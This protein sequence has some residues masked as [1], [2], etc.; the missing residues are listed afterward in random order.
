VGGGDSGAVVAFDLASGKEKWKWSGDAPAYASPVVITVGD[1][2]LVIAETETKL[3]ALGLTDGKLMWEIPF[4]VPGRGYNAATPI[5]D[6]DKLIY[7]G[8][9]RGATAV[10][11]EKKGDAVTAQ[12]L[13]K[14]PDNSVMFDTPVLKNGLLFGLSAANDFFCV[15]AKDGKTVW[16]ASSAPATAGD[17][18]GGGGGRGGRGRGGYGSIVDAGSVLLALTPSSELIAFE[19]NAKA[20]NEIARIKIAET[21]THAYP[22]ASGNRLF[23]KDQDAVTLWTVP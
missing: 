15:D 14:N 5:V 23:I 7:A 18:P 19:P 10:K 13:W 4:P 20:Y 16:T 11:L 21:P 8:S 12:E 6:G 17:A 3:A 22:V 9:G 2:K 1:A